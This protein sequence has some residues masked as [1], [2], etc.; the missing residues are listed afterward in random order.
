M[1]VAH[2]PDDETKDVVRGLARSGVPHVEIAKALEITKPT[3]YKHYSQILKLGAKWADAKVVNGL[4]HNATVEGNVTAQIFWLKARCGWR[5]RD[6]VQTHIHAGAESAEGKTLMS[7]L[8][9]AK[10]YKPDEQDEEFL[11]ALEK[12]GSGDPARN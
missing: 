1:P 11:R 12:R 2:K 10:E 3:L 9:A 7:A 8:K 4:F 5:D 6:P